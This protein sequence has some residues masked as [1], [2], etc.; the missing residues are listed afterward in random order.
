MSWL[1]RYIQIIHDY[2]YKISYMIR[3]FIYCYRMC[4]PIVTDSP[5]TLPL[6]P[7]R[8][9][10]VLEMS[11]AAGT[12]VSIAGERCQ[13]QSD[14]CGNPVFLMCLIYFDLKIAGFSIFQL[15][16]HISN[17][18]LSQ[19]GFEYLGFSVEVCGAAD[20]EGQAGYSAGASGTSKE[21]IFFC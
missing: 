18:R 8:W 9:T 7:G 12:E 10:E 14:A 11:H 17:P 3:V 2:F 13:C 20:F 4:F 1:F 21:I 5:V 6:G 19:V 16:Q 15:F